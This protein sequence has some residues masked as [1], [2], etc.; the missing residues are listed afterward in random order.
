MSADLIAF[1]STHGDNESF[2]NKRIRISA[3]GQ[4]VE[5]LVADTCGDHDCGGCCTEN[6]GS[7]GYVVDME[8]WT[9]V[10]NF[11]SADVADGVVCWQ[12]I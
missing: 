5:A 9:V 6:A 1:F 3:L 11:G 10:N 12:L 7:I 4:T 2:G 8:Y